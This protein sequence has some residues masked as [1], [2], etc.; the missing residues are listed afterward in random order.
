MVSSKLVRTTCS[1]ILLAGLVPL[2]WAAS[3]DADYEAGL[4]E[5][6]EFHYAQALA[7]F[8]QAA[9]Q[10]HR[11]ALRT[12]GLMLLYGSDLYGEEVPKDWIKAVHLLSEAALKGCR[13]SAR[14]LQRI[15]VRNQG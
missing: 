4:Q 6:Q 5:A 1:A 9:A 7:H 12:A 11:D 8:D 14:V 15:G 10:G 13:V 2:T 3:P